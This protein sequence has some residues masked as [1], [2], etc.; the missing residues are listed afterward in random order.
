MA[1]IVPLARHRRALTS[2]YD[3]LT[4][5]FMAISSALVADGSDAV[6]MNGG[7]LSA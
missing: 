7:L 1:S 6:S 4:Q 3:A 5:I 2:K